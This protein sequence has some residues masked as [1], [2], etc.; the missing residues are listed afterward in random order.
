MPL[1]VK[2]SA[3]LRPYVPD[4]D[5]EKGLDLDLDYSS[6]VTAADIAVRL[7]VPPE[8]IKFIMLNGRCMA[9]DTPLNPGDRLAFFPAVG[10]G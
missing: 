4:Y 2:L 10:G 5:P 6:P 7:G 8:E 9:M 1:H 3:T